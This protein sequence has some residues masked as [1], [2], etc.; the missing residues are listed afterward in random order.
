M[1]AAQNIVEDCLCQLKCQFYPGDEKENHL[2]GQVARQRGIF[3]PETEY[4]KI[5]DTRHHHPEVLQM[6]MRLLKPLG[7]N[8]DTPS[9]M[10]G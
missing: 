1:I 9:T 2:S 5:L 4:R 7:N 3:L 10:L 6:D 8:P